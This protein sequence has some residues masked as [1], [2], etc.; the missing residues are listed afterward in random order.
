MFSRILIPIDGSPYSKKAL[1][2]GCDFAK[3]YDASITLLHVAYDSAHEQTMVLGSSAVTFQIDQEEVDQTG[4]FILDAGYSLAAELGC[5]SIQ[6][7]LK[8][9]KPAEEIVNALYGLPP[10]GTDIRV[11]HVVLIGGGCRVPYTEIFLQHTLGLGQPLLAHP[12]WCDAG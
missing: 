1:E 10:V 11:Q 9:G 5:P 4:R 6:T 8:R 2:F 7:R 12:L 3:K